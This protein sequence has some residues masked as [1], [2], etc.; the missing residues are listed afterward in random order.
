M[1][2]MVE[3]VAEALYVAFPKITVG[4]ADWHSLTSMH[5]A[6]WLTSARAAIESMRV[7]TDEMEYAGEDEPYAAP[8]NVWVAMI[9]EALK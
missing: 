4:G 6:A 9:N 2:G 1:S 7:P 8:R 3:R 5:R